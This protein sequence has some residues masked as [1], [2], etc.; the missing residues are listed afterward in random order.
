MCCAAL[1]RPAANG[2]VSTF[3]RLFTALLAYGFVTYGLVA[4]DSVGCRAPDR[5]PT[6]APFHPFPVSPTIRMV[7]DRAGLMPARVLAQLA[8]QVVVG[9]DG[10]VSVPSF[11]P[12][13]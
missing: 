11:T 1:A 9:E 3:E 12:S 10:T 5:S 7:A 13:R 6:R 2:L 8:E 4:Y